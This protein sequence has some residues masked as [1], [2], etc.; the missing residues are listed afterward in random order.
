MK[1]FELLKRATQYLQKKKIS[2]ARLDA[3]ILLAGVL[4]VPRLD[5]ILLKDKKINKSAAAKFKK[6]IIRH[7]KYEPVAYILGNTEFMS[8]EFFVN[9]SVLIPRPDTET[10]VEEIIKHVSG[11]GIKKPR[12][13]DIGTGSGV[14]AVSLAKYIKDAEVTAADISLRALCVAL[15]N[16]KHNSVG[17][18]LA[19]PE[20][21]RR[22]PAHGKEEARVPL[23]IKFVK[24]DLFGAFRNK[25][26]KFDIIVSN[27]PYVTKSELKKLSLFIRKHEPV[28]ALDGGKDGLEIIKKIIRQAPDYLKKGGILAFEV[29]YKQAEKVKKLME[30]AGFQNIAVIKDLAGINRVLIAS[31]T[32]DE[33]LATSD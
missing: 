14:I 26:V 15:K 19:C 17:A 27:P 11:A 31:L 10:L 25:N 5:F 18:G 9:K 20:L 30:D 6:F 4:K 13:L 32:S 33:R 21:C 22:A 23:Q 16:A 1:I 2:M 29:G 12:I 3:E 28:T 7:A 8:L 24:S